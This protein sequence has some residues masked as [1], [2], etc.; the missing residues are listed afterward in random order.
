MP[1]V[2][3]LF[4]TTF[5]FS[6]VQV[7][8]EDHIVTYKKECNWLPFIHIIPDVDNFHLSGLTKLKEKNCIDEILSA[9]SKFLHVES[10]ERVVASLK[11]HLKQTKEFV[12]IRPVSVTTY[13]TGENTKFIWN[14]IFNYDIK[15][16][17]I[18]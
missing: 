15:R 6:L 1:V 3:C 16:F 10:S 9:Q 18:R 12:K 17:V 8:D 14:N 11:E 2:H 7:K 5:L 13:K 4:I